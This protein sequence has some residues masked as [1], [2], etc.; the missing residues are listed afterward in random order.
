MILSNATSTFEL[1]PSPYKVSWEN[2]EALK[3]VLPAEG[4][5]V[6]IR[7]DAGAFVLKIKTNVNLT[8]GWMDQAE[9]AF[10][11]ADA[12]A[13]AKKAALKA[14][15]SAW[16]A[17]VVESNTKLTKGLAAV[18]KRQFAEVERNIAEEDWGMAQCYASDAADLIGIMR[19]LDAGNQATARRLIENL[20]TI[21]RDGIPENIWQWIHA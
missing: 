20:D 17:P 21:V 1:D 11:A 16:T 4:V 7:E 9:L 5:S 6:D 13:K 12:A 18:I 2:L 8:P 3:T 14:K 10:Q 15:M 19:E